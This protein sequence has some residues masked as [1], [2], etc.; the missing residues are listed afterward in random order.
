MCSKKPILFVVVL[1]VLLF[2]ALTAFAGSES[3]AKSAVGTWKLDS[4]KSSFGNMP[5]PKFEQM[6]VSKDEPT[7]IQWTVTGAMSDG[8][9]YT[10]SYDG[11]IDGK[12]HN[13]KVLVG[14][15]P[16]TIAYTRIASGGLQW[17]VK[18]A[19]GSIVE[20]GMGQ[21]SSDGKTLSLKGT[22]AGPKGKE[23]FVAVYTR[24]K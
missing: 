8:K 14:N 6:V 19:K 4:A 13:V 15:G 21:L 16:A 24:I 22:M 10:E 2:I 7:A 20:T 18:D 23:N 3:S 5:A 9:S 11:P 12:D 17:T 1:T